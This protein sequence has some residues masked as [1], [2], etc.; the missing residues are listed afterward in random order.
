MVEIV[1]FDLKNTLKE[2][3]FFQQNEKI[4]PIYIELAEYTLLTLHKI[5]PFSSDFDDLS[6]SPEN[7]CFKSFVVVWADAF[8][9]KKMSCI[10]TIKQAIDNIIN[11][12]CEYPPSLPQVI[13]AYFGRLEK[14]D[15]YYSGISHQNFY[16]PDD[17]L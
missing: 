6:G 9:S 8:M 1:K 14:R 4:E 16:V 13:A 5:Y 10:H 3:D 15:L 17:E 12:E 2:S 11:L 7:E